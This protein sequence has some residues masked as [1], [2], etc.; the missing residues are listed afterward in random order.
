M[1]LEIVIIIIIVVIK[2][3]QSYVLAHVLSTMPI[4]YSIVIYSIRYF[5]SSIRY[6]LHALHTFPASAGLIKFL[7]PP[8]IHFVGF[9][10][11]Y[12]CGLHPTN[13]A[14]GARFGRVFLLFCIMDSPW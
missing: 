3:V 10:E 2:L 7:C 4:N 13:H 9:Q 1:K 11:G 14:M 8:H 5:V 12:V 6:A